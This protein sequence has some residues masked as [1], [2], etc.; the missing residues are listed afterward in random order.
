[1]EK[2]EMKRHL[3]DLDVDGRIMS[4]FI[5]NKQDRA[6]PEFIW[7]R[8]GTSG[9]IFVNTEINFQFSWNMGDILTSGEATSL[10]KENSHRG[11]S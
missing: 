11:V 2:S 7:L 9:D 3:D 1:M 4:K 8:I 5:L 10:L 6:W